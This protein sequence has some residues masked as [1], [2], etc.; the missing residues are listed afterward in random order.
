M[1]PDEGELQSV[2]SAHQAAESVWTSSSG[3]GFPEA[4]VACNCLLAEET[5]SAVAVTPV[6]S[7]HGS[8]CDRVSLA[9]TK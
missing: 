9:K 2:G 5:G 8:D 1:A 7:V 3:C 6:E 4:A